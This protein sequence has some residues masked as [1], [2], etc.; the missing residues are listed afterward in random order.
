MVQAA[1]KAVNQHNHPHTGYILTTLVLSTLPYL[2]SSSNGN[3]SRRFW[4]ESHL[5]HPLE[6]L[7]GHQHYR[8]AFQPG[9]GA[10]GDLVKGRAGGRRCGG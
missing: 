2:V 6:M 8:S 9:T 7:C 1:Q 5:L 4:V 10:Q 3:T